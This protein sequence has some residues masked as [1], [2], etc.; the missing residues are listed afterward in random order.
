[1]AAMAIIGYVVAFVQSDRG[2]V[3]YQ[4][5]AEAATACHHHILDAGAVQLNCNMVPDVRKH[6]IEH[7]EA[8]AIG[9]PFLN[10]ALSLSLVMIVS[11]LLRKAVFWLLELSP[12]FSTRVTVR[13]N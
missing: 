3:A 5:Y 10:L 1:M 4:R 2:A 13:N 11:P 7:R 9:E 8:F 12:L 6:L